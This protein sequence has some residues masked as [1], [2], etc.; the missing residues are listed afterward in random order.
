MRQLDHGPKLCSWCAFRFRDLHFSIGS[1]KL[2]VPESTNWFS[3]LQI[4]KLYDIVMLQNRFKSSPFFRKLNNPPITVL[5]CCF[6]FMSNFLPS[7]ISYSYSV[8][9]IAEPDKP[10]FN[11]F[12]VYKKSQVPNSSFRNCQSFTALQSFITP[13]LRKFQLCSWNVK[14]LTISSK[15]LHSLHKIFLRS[16]FFS[17]SSITWTFS[18][19]RW[20]VGVAW[21]KWWEPGDKRKETSRLTSWRILFEGFPRHSSQCLCLLWT[22]R[23]LEISLS[24]FLFT[25]PF[26]LFY[27]SIPLTSNPLPHCFLFNW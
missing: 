2:L 7:W 5:K 8:N 12:S 15:T 11:N 21:P 18:T 6:Q 13:N 4:P 19:W 3:L 24:F 1:L 10:L 9:S 23:E 16:L 26:L 17:S 27:H 20:K 22:P 25:Y 14:V